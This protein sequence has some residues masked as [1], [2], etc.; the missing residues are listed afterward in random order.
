MLELIKGFP[1]NV[2]AI[3]ASG[4]VT[5]KDYNDV[6]IP[7]AKKAFARYEKIRVYYE[8]S[9]K[10]TGFAPAA[11]WEDFKFGMEHFF[12]WE[13][14]AVVTDVEWVR[15]TINALRFMF[16]GQAQVFKVAEAKAAKEWIT[17][18]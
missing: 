7:A 2:V 5:R 8:I 11:A 6:L 3:S 12:H 14:I 13:R 15:L 17:S 10:F 16:P 1:E 4:M 18:L 9:P